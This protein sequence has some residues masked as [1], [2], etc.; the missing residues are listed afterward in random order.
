MPQQREMTPEQYAALEPDKALFT[1]RI[2]AGAL[3]GGVV[4][5]AGVASVVVFSQVPAAQPG[6]QPPAGPQN[7]SEIL[8]YLAMA[9]A[10]V[11]AVMSFVV[12]N[13]VSA[14]GVKGVARMAQ[15]GTATGPKELF[16][17]L[18]AVAQTKMIIAMALVEGAAFFNL[19]AFISTKSLIPPAVV[20]ALLLVMTIHF[21]TKLKLARWLEDQ[22]RFLS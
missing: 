20:G 19:I 18:L 17:R 12:S 6:G 15:D 11:A 9:L 13:L 3:I 10:A 16:G 2:I 1:M 4:M 7:G 5:F 8:M 22:Q 21:P 14:A